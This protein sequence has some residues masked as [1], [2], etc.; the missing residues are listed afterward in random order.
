VAQCSAVC[1]DYGLQI[2]IDRQT[3]RQTDRHYTVDMFTV[4]RGAR[5]S[6]KCVVGGVQD[7]DHDVIFFPDVLVIRTDCRHYLCY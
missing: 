6:S 3:D 4:S 2:R 1:M 5:L 7:F